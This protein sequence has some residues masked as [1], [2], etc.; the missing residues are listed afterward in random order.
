MA[1]ATKNHWIWDRIESS[2]NA[3]RAVALIIFVV[4]VGAVPVVGTGYHVQ[5]LFTIFLFTTLGLGWNLLSGF[6]GY[7]NFG[8]A[9]FV[10]IGAYATVLPMVELGAPWYAALLFATIVTGIV[11][12]LIGYPVLRL[13][14]AYFAIATLAI[15]TATGILAATEYLRP[16]TQ[17]ASGISFFPPVSNDQQFY[18]MA[19]LMLVTALI[20]FWV[21]TSPFG[22]RL[23]AIRED[24]VLASSLGVNTVWDK[25]AA[26]G[27]HTAVGGVCGGMLA[28]NL[29]YIDPT[30]V[31]HIQYTEY[32]II[33]VL[34]GGLGTAA[35]PIVGGIVIGVLREV[36]WAQAPHF[37]LAILGV[38]IVILILFLPEG[39][40][41][42]LKENEYIPRRRWL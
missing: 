24:E 9:G 26:M 21:A 14:G 7:I 10:G 2:S 37:H 22:L 38:L 31:F 40:I 18:I 32:P 30:T 19:G 20:T 11:G 15:A 28:L 16:L 1:T 4:F 41:E 27:I 8:Y 33:M 23:I 12:L 25:M 36:L 35:G 5:F 6:T 34:F 3:E 39:A 42:W 13:D 17:G 29:S